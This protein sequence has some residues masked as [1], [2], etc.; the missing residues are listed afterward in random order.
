MDSTSC[1]L[2]VFLLKGKVINTHYVPID[3]HINKELVSSSAIILRVSLLVEH[4]FLRVCVAKFYD[5]H[6]LIRSVLRKSKL[7]VF[8]IHNEN[9]VIM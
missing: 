8:K 2:H 4:R 9:N 7:S 3:L 6:R 1:I 5:R